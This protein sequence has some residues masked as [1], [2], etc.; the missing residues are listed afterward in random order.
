MTHWHGKGAKLLFIS[1][2]HFISHFLSQIRRWQP[3]SV[4]YRGSMSSITPTTKT[5]LSSQGKAY[6][7]QNKN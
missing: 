4:S 6:K 5:M 7:K 3:A 2:S 1:F